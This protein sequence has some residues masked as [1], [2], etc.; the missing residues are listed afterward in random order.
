MDI[1]A[2]PSLCLMCGDPCE[3]GLFAVEPVWGCSGC[4]RQL[5]C[6]C[7]AHTHP[8]CFSSST[9]AAL[10][11]VSAAGD[12]DA[13]AVRGIAEHSKPQRQK[14]PQKPQ[15]S[16]RQVEAT[17]GKQSQQHLQQQHQQQQP[18]VEQPSVRPKPLPGVQPLSRTVADAAVRACST[19][20]QPSSPAPRTRG[21]GAFSSRPEAESELEMK[22]PVGNRSIS[23]G[24]WVS[25]TGRRRKSSAC[26][27]DLA[28]D[29]DHAPSSQCQQRQSLDRQ[30]KVSHVLVPD[31]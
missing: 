29:F 5:H 12:P 30:V 22:E 14:Q 8:D 23:S 26:A 20:R 27:M 25:A 31:G 3:V 18:E 6:Q 9:L 13:A 24:G 16:P 11:C 10:R 28:G 4:K 1:T 2:M 7:Y 21:S 15:L 19:P 17:K